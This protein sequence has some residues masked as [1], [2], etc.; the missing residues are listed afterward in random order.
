MEGPLDRSIR[1][2]PQRACG[3]SQCH[4]GRTHDSSDEP[5]SR[6]S[7]TELDDTRG[8]EQDCETAASGNQHEDCSGVKMNL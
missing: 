4:A 6:E 2:W 5:K 8:N 7:E 3:N 1:D